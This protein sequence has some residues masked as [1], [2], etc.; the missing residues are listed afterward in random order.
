MISKV[1]IKMV[2]IRGALYVGIAVLQRL[3]EILTSAEPPRWGVTIVAL[4]L[5]A[6]LTLRAYLDES[7]ANHKQ[8]QSEP[9]EVTATEP[10]PVEVADEE[11]DDSTSNKR[12]SNLS[13]T[14]LNRS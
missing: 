8:G 5:S 1:S 2:W 10:L 7:S 12:P 11:S 14:V 9:I 4:L 3:Y 6:F 13:K